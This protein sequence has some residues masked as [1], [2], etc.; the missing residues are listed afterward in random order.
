MQAAAP[1][2][3][4]RV[5]IHPTTDKRVQPM[6]NVRLKIKQEPYN[7]KQENV[8][9]EPMNI[10]QREDTNVEIIQP[11]ITNVVQLELINAIQYEPVNIVQP[12][13]TNIKTEGFSTEN[14]KVK[15]EVNNEQS[16]DEVKPFMREYR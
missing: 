8:K 9:P 6:K 11:E 16:I 7:I 10:V 4:R 2:R 5:P 13:P 12:E 15:L 1:Q 14:T 3:R